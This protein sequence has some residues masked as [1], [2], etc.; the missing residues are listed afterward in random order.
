MISNSRRISKVIAL[1]DPLGVKIG[2]IAIVGFINAFLMFLFSRT[3]GRQ[4]VMRC[5]KRSDLYSI[6]VVHTYN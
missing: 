3:P 4:A 2:C 6:S 1:D 5:N